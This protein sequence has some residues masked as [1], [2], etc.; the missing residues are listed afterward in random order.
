MRGHMSAVGGPISSRGALM[1]HI[2]DNHM[3]VKAKHRVG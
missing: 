2:S 3:I 1:S